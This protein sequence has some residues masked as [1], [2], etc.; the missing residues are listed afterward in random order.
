MSNSL[1]E[2]YQIAAEHHDLQYFKEMLR[3]HE[4]RRVEEAQAAADAAAEKEAKKEAKKELKKSKSK[5][6][7]TNVDDDVEMVDASDEPS[8]K[9]ASKKRKKESD[10]STPKV[11]QLS[12][13]P[14]K[15]IFRLT[16]VKLKLKL[17]AAAEEQSP[18]PK[19]ARK[20]KPAA[21]SE[22]EQVAKPRAPEVQLTPAEK[23]KK[24]EKTSKPIQG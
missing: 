10:E 6:K 23:L 13:N 22:E 14:V 19:K 16:T 1:W 11:N 8:Q 5:S 15:L 18:K 20:A 12:L 17:K 4:Q 3:E 2:A 7:L 9:A 24:R 21:D